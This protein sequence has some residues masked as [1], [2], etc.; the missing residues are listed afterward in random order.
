[1]QF[2]YIIAHQIDADN[3]LK[4]MEFRY[5]MWYDDWHSRNG[6]ELNERELK[7]ILALLY[8]HCVDTGRGG[9]LAD[10]EL[11]SHDIDD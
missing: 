3:R 6:G 2:L 8:H 7:I 11:W 9:S 10:Q 1:M 5:K 4:R